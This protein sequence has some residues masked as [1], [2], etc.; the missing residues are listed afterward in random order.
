[1]SASPHGTSA[2]GTECNPQSCKTASR[3]NPVIV[4]LDCSYG[5]ACELA[6]L[7]KPELSWAKVGMELFYACGSQVV[8][9][10][11]REGYKVFLDLKLHDIPNTVRQA[12]RTVSALGVDMLTVHASGG[13]AMIEA[14][15]AG[16]EEGAAQAGVRAPAILAVTV[17][18]SMDQKE[19]SALGV[20]RSLEGHAG[21]LAQRAVAHGAHGVICSPREAALMR[22]ALPAGSLIV[23]PGV[24][25]PGAAAHDQSRITTPRDAIAAGATHL[26]VGRPISQAA[27]PVAAAHEVVQQT[28]SAL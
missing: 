27:D 3:E 26:V 24:R 13:A 22:G 11:Q 12:A 17:L 5:R 25:P 15:R 23:T 10:L 20:E 16:S 1:M 19:L 9:D 18:T 14:A 28:L 2:A 21:A 4:A 8:K 7:L 6:R